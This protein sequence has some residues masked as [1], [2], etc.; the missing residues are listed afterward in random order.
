MDARKW[1]PWMLAGVL[2]IM[3]FWGVVLVFWCL[4]LVAWVHFETRQPAG[5]IIIPRNAR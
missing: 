2:A 1:V 5:V 4:G 3:S